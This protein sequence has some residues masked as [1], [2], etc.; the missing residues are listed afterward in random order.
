MHQTAV[1]GHLAYSCSENW[2]ISTWVSSK[3]SRLMHGKRRVCPYSRSR[4]HINS[5]GDNP[6][7]TGPPPLSPSDT[8][9]RSATSQLGRYYRNEL[10]HPKSLL[11]INALRWRC[12]AVAIRIDRNLP[13]CLLYSV[14]LVDWLTSMTNFCLFLHSH[15]WLMTI[16][17]GM[18]PWVA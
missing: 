18:V 2:R 9:G 6:P 7:L 10:A 1:E 4:G 12:F 13:V 8:T 11:L 14:L 3:T 5:D 17:Q 16:A 15:W